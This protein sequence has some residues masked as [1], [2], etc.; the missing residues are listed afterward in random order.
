MKNKKTLASMVAA[1][2][3]ATGGMV[4]AEPAQA[5]S[6]GSI[7]GDILCN[8]DCDREWDRAQRRA[9]SERDRQYNDR[10][11]DR[12]QRERELRQV[13]EAA[14]RYVTRNGGDYAALRNC[15]TQLVAR[16]GMRAYTAIELCASQ[17]FNSSARNAPVQRAP[18][19]RQPSRP[20]ER[21]VVS[22]DQWDYMMRLCIDDL[23]AQNPRAT[24]ADAQARMYRACEQGFSRYYTV[25]NARYGR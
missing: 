7:I 20:T 16:E 24:G 5:Q 23:Q 2:L 6:A 4:A 13:P 17:M 1:A 19:Y 11:N 9:Q 14:A 21:Q 18:E 15:G 10:V 12:R 8:G 22:Q 3:A 25:R